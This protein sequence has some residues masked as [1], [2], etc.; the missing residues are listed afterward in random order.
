MRHRHPEALPIGSHVP[1]ANVRENSEQL[2]VSGQAIATTL[3]R[4]ALKQ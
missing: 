1:T 3:E 2:L 4:V